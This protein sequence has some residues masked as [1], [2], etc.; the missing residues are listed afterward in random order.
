[1]WADLLAKEGKTRD[2]LA[3]YDQALKNAPNWKALKAAREALA[4]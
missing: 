1:V 4:K 3:Q 2:A